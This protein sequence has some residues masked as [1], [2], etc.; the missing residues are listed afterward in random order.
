MGTF[1]IMI[2]PTFWIFRRTFLPCKCGTLGPY[3][4][5]A[6]R[7]YSRIIGKIVGCCYQSHVGLSLLVGWGC[8]GIALRNDPSLSYG[9][10]IVYYFTTLVVL[11]IMN[12]SP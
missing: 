7:V 1:G 8:A 11:G 6:I 9:R 4:Y 10:C 5:S 2:G 12:N 3:M